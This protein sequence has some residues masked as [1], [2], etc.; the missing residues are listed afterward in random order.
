L[1]PSN[2]SDVSWGALSS[3]FSEFCASLI[4]AQAEFL[5]VG[6]YAV[7]F[8]GAP[9]FTGDF[10]V[11]VRPTAE[12]GD[13]VL[14]ALAIFGFPTSRLTPESFLN[15]ATLVEMGLPPLQIHLM[16]SISGVTWEEAWA[17]RSSIRLG[18]S[19]VAVIGRVEL[20]RNKRAAGRSKDLADLEALGGSA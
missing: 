8:H 12:N 2:S 15:S 10:D 16:T 7:A 13:R 14:R 1:P 6:A 20:L 3:E 19:D 11:L 18:S 9:R 17:G 4:A 5:V